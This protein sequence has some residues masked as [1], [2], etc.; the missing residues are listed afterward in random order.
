M[1]RRT[2]AGDDGPLIDISI[3]VGPDTPAWPGDT[4][5]SCGWTWEIARGESVNVS[6]VTTSPHVGTH[7]DAPLHVDAA[8]PGSDALPLETFTGPATVVDVSEHDGPLDLDALGLTSR[9]IAGGRLLLKT[10]RSVVSGTFPGSWPWISERAAHDLLGAGL[11]LLG[12]DAPSVDARDSTSLGVHR[13]LFAGGA[14]VLESLDLRAVTAG[15]YHLTALPLRWSGLDAAP[16]RA[17]LRS[18]HRG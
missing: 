9:G 3:L 13:V 11:R 6:A 18:L 10:G 5:F 2:A 15:E 7:A 16:V 8:L 4:A 17:V 12:V 1:T 14:G